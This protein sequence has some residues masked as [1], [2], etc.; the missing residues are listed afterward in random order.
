MKGRLRCHRVGCR[1]GGVGPLASELQCLKEREFALCAQRFL[2]C[3]VRS[4]LPTVKSLHWVLQGAIFK[5]RLELG[6]FGLESQKPIL[7]VGTA[8]YLEALARNMSK[9]ERAAMKRHTTRTHSFARAVPLLRRISPVPEDAL[10]WPGCVSGISSRRCG[11]VCGGGGFRQPS[12][13][14]CRAAVVFGLVAGSPPDRPGPGH[15]QHSSLFCSFAGSG[16]WVEAGTCPEGFRSS[17][18]RL[19]VFRWKL[20][21]VGFEWR[22]RCPEDPLV[23][24]P[25]VPVRALTYVSV[26]WG[27]RY[28]LPVIQAAGPGFV[29]APVPPFEPTGLVW[30]LPFEQKT[31]PH[32]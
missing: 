27:R 11:A 12:W 24:P 9:L 14:T 8:P 6:C 7:L 5:A 3:G 15:H 2:G 18:G 32:Q 23:G 30:I 13:T 29:I 4:V 28:G 20:L 1:W 25:H 21:F 26:I 16:P 31:P 22:L 10:G 17:R 19:I